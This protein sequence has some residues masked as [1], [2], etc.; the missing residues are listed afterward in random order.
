VRRSREDAAETRRKIVVAASRLFR[1]RGIAAVS[2]ADI[3]SSLGLTVGG[4]YRHFDSKEALVAEAIESAS[5]ETTGSHE[6]LSKKVGPS[7][8]A[9]VILEKY[10]SNTHRMNPER[11]CPVAALGSE[12]GHEGKPTKA[13][14]TAALKRLVDMVDRHTRTGT[15]DRRK[16]VLATAA[17]MVGAVVLARATTDDE[18]AAELLAAVRDR[19]LDSRPRRK[20][21][22]TLASESH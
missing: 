4:F 8:S 22:R 13:A 18:L 3:M 2:V 14:F 12:V 9:K 7:D 17:A 21:R 5:L 20:R 6:E 1:A 11:G 16:D 19:T 10:L 15:P